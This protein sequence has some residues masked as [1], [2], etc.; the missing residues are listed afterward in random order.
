[1]P[2]ACVLSDR[3]LHLDIYVRRI[4]AAVECDGEYWHQFPTAK[5]RDQ[6]KSELCR[7]E[8]IKLFRVKYSCYARGILQARPG[9]S[10]P[11]SKDCVRA[12]RLRD[13]AVNVHGT[14]GAPLP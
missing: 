3:R 2:N 7:K 14:Q 11:N 12:V 8:G 9:T 4:G 6:R 1:M 10:S 5:R 13:S